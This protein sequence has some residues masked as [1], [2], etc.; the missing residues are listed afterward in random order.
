MPMLMLAVVGTS[1]SCSSSSSSRKTDRQRR[2]ADQKEN[3]SQP[4][5]S[6]LMP[7]TPVELF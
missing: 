4:T 1:S 2:N 3:Y 6:E 5:H 7:I